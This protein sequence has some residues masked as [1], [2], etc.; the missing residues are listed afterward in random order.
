MQKIRIIIN[1]PFGWIFILCY[2]LSKERAKI[3]LDIDRFHRI[4]AGCGA[5]NYIWTLYI[6]Y[7]LA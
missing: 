4:V 3:N 5:K 1:L 2:L 6:N 7:S